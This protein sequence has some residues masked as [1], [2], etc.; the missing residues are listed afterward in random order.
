MKNKK[1]LTV[2]L[3]VLF[4]ILL[5]PIVEANYQMNPNGSRVYVSLNDLMNNMRN[6]EA[7]GQ[8]MGLKETHDT[9]T[10]LPTTEENG[11]DVH[12]QKNTEYGACILLSASPKY[13]K[14]GTGS[15]SYIHTS[16]ST[17]IAT[18]TGN[19]YG[20]YDMGN[21]NWE[22]TAGGGVNSYYVSQ[23]TC[24]KVPYD[25]RYY[26]I[27]STLVTKAGDATTETSYWKGSS[28]PD[29]GNRD[30]QAFI[31]GNGSAFNFVDWIPK[32]SSRTCGR[33]VAVTGVS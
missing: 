31:R 18:T 24:K 2:V 1:T 10:L 7:E 28:G 8:V 3:V 30:D 17:G 19:Q 14:Q 11:I 33:A 21:D 32:G 15:D 16:T 22:W 4:L 20:V 26:N 6:M 25:S 5:T 23:T 13:G 12:M 9:T 29:F 27:Y